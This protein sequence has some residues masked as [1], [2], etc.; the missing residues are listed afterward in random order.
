MTTLENKEIRGLNWR[1][2]LAIVLATGS[3]VTTVLVSYHNLSAQ[4][5]KT[6]TTQE[7]TQVMYNADARYSDLRMTVLE[8]TVTL[9]QLQI[10]NLKR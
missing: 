3:I 7:R 6:Q 10:D 1:G 9:L 5:V 2:L 4:I 8:K